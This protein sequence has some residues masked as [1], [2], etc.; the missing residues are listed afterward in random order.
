MKK[1]DNANLITWLHFDDSS[2]VLYLVNKAQVMTDFW[3]YHETG[4][5]G[6]PWLQ[7]IDKHVGQDNIQGMYFLPKK[8]VNFMDNE[9]ERGVRYT[10]K[11]AEYVSFKV[12]RMS[13]AFQEELYPDCKANESV[14]SFEEWAEGQNKDPAMHKFDPSKVEKNASATKR[15]KTFKAKVGGGAGV[16]N[17]MEESK[18][19]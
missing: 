18:E 10:G 3:Y 16:S 13:G 12:K 14:H 19:S 4:P 11:V 1:L 15:Q 6:K 7:Q 9:L 5:D 17:F 2:N 8:D